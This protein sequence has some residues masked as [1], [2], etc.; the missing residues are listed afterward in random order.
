MKA[1]VYITANKRNG[2]L[3]VGVTSDLIKRVWQHKNKLIDG[4]T[5]K[6]DVNLLVYYEEHDDIKEAIQR[7]K[8]IKKWERAWKLRIIEEM[9]PNWDDLY[10]NIIQ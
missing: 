7:E 3:Y 2:T 6:Y 4:F 9:N 10:N 5:N 8:R 1:Y